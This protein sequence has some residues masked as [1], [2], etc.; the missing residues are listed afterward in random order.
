[1]TTYTVTFYKNIFLVQITEMVEF[2]EQITGAFY[3]EAIHANPITTP[4]G[5]PGIETS[6]L[7]EGYPY[8]ITKSGEQRTVDIMKHISA[9]TTMNILSGF[10]RTSVPPVAVLNAQM[11]IGLYYLITN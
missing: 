3:P 5:S 1:M 7:P 9:G 2:R 11:N 10:L 8:L 6:M 4:L